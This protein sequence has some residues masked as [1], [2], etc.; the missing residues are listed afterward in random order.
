MCDFVYENGEQCQ[1]PIWLDH[2]GSKH[3]IL[4]GQTFG[5][6]GK[7]KFQR[8]HQKQFFQVFQNAGRLIDDAQEYE[9]VIFP[10]NFEVILSKRSHYRFKKCKTAEFLTI[11]APNDITIH[12]EECAGDTLEFQL[13]AR[14]ITF[15]NCDQF[16][17]LVFKGGQT[18]GKIGIKDCERFDSLT[19]EF[20]QGLNRIQ[21]EN[22]HVGTLT[23]KDNHDGSL[24]VCDC[25]IESFNLSSREGFIA[26]FNDTTIERASSVNG[27]FNGRVVEFKG[28][29]FTENLTIHA[30]Q[31]S[32]IS[33]LP[34]DENIS[35]VQRLCIGPEPFSGNINLKGSH[36]QTLLIDC[37][38]IDGVLNTDGMTVHHLR[39]EPKSRKTG[40]YKTIDLHGITV[41]GRADIN[42]VACNEFLCRDA[43]FK[44]TANF[45]DCHFM[46]TA[47]FYQTHFQ[48]DAKFACRE[49]KP[50]T[51][52]GSPYGQVSFE[53]AH[54]YK[55]ADFTNHHFDGATSFDQTQFHYAPNFDGVT[56]AQHTTMETAIFHD[57]ERGQVEKYAPERY[58]TLKYKMEE[59]RDRRSQGKFF[60]C[61]QIA[62]RI[63][64]R[65]SPT[66][67][68]LSH[69]Y[70]FTSDYGMDVSRP[71]QLI[72]GTYLLFTFLYTILGVIDGCTSNCLSNAFVEAL[73]HVF[74]PFH[75]LK[76]IS[77]GGTIRAAIGVIQS[78]I[79]YSL[80][81]LFLISVRWR[82]KKD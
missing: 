8:Q 14:E 27:Q 28:T 40:L 59:L 81:A 54:F 34:S 55:D 51:H 1:L 75:A 62:H 52:D 23:A 39:I 33:F 66:E 4:H 12:F 5:T 31:A 70:G 25:T 21:V 49:T 71:I 73:K 56:L 77:E 69:L 22:S 26:S 11:K 29:T 43:I 16:D 36:A 3:C 53:L 67:R 82:F 2:T 80:F 44:G 32:S 18:N 76:S 61:E 64:G 68:V 38:S 41:T 74:V 72:F 10:P 65:K 9:G 48:E 42:H 24:Y 17:A 47:S 58:R 20:S 6:M 13:N 57:V 78:L 37:E 19:F 46:G 60:R 63:L 7:N 50:E 79:T 30:S 45:V 35:S 15:D